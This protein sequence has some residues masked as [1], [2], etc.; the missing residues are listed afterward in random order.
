MDKKMLKYVFVLVGGVALIILLLV[1]KNSLKKPSKT[2][3]LDL[4]KKVINATKKYTKDHPG[5]L[6]QTSGTSITIGTNTLVEKGY[7]KELSSYVKEDVNCNGIVEIYK[8]SFDEYDYSPNIT[9]GAKYVTK[10]LADKVIYD[11]DGDG[12]LS[13]MGLYKKVNDKFVTT[14][15][16]DSSVKVE[17]YFR[18][19]VV[20]NYLKIGDNMWRIVGIDNDYNTILIFE[21]S[22]RKGFAWDDRYNEETGKNHGINTYEHLGI[23]SRIY[24]TVN[25]FFD[26]DADLRDKEKLSPIVKNIIVPFDVCMGHR[27]QDEKD[28]TG[29]V[30]CKEILK[31]QYVSLLPAYLFMN[32]SLDANCKVLTDKNCGNYNF[33]AAFNDYW[34]LLT[35]DAANT[36]EAYLVHKTYVKPSLCQAK[37]NVRPVIKISSRTLYS[38]GDGSIN[39]PYTIKH[40]N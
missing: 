20:K 31:D 35:P 36:S 19:D 30:E 14:N 40:F 2:T 29:S 38:E 13:G 28:T 17:Y 12:V 33:L 32:A 23:K 9:C 39:N 5:A 22:F 1:L 26:K 27:K 4:E 34:W 6:P 8:S 25:S 24:E 7:I 11:N 16:S 3:Y 10:K 21:K 15:F 37:N 18:G